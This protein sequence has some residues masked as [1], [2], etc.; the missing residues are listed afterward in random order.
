MLEKNPVVT[1]IGLNPL[2]MIFLYVKELGTQVDKIYM[3][4]RS[5]KI[6][7]SLM[8]WN[9]K[10]CTFFLSIVKVEEKER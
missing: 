6:S 8:I 2:G 1:V 4:S 5:K 7:N 9:W 10:S 3:A